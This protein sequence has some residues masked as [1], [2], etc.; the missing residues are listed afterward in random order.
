MTG[1]SVRESAQLPPCSS[2][3]YSSPLSICLRRRAHVW[4]KPLIKGAGHDWLN[5]NRNY[6]NTHALIVCVIL[7]SGDH[8]TK[9]LPLLTGLYDIESNFR[10]THEGQDEARPLSD[11]ISEQT[12]N[13][14]SKINKLP[15]GS[16]QKPVKCIIVFCSDS[17]T[18]AEES[19]DF[20][21]QSSSQKQV[22]INLYICFNGT[23]T[24]LSTFLCTIFLFRK[25]LNA[26]VGRLLQNVVGFFSTLMIIKYIFRENIFISS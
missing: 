9:R 25:M 10:A 15:L 4:T 11:S 20:T 26:F 8:I 5:I 12:P 14:M 19:K 18:K 3:P 17:E 21:E 7:R 16:L 23:F 13:K 1:R 22:S 6:T 24:S 2:P